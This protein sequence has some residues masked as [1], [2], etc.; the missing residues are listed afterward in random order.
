MVTEHVP[1]SAGGIQLWAEHPLLV[2]E[3]LPGILEQIQPESTNGLR[4]ILQWSSSSN[5]R[6]QW[7]A[8]SKL[9]ESKMPEDAPLSTAEKELL[10]QEKINSSIENF[11]APC[12]EFDNQSVQ[13]YV[14]R[15]I[16]EVA[17]HDFAVRGALGRQLFQTMSWAL[18][19]QDVADNPRYNPHDYRHAMVVAR[20]MADLARAEP[21]LLD[22]FTERYA[23][24]RTQ[25]LALIQLSGLLHDCGY[26]FMA[27]SVEPSGEPSKNPAHPVL[28]KATHAAVGGL[29]F[30]VLVQPALSRLLA[31]SG[32][33]SSQGLC[34]EMMRA[35]HLHS[36]DTPSRHD[37]DAMQVSTV[38]G[39]IY[40]V[41]DESALVDLSQKLSAMGDPISRVKLHE[42]DGAHLAH[43]S[44]LLPDDVIVT[45][46]ANPIPPARVL[47][48]Q[49]VGDRALATPCVKVDRQKIPMAYW[50][51]LADNLDLTHKRLGA[52][53]G[54]SVYGRSLLKFHSASDLQNSLQEIKAHIQENYA[55]RDEYADSAAWPNSPASVLLHVC[56]TSKKDIDFLVGL[57]SV[58]EVSLESRT[59]GQTVVVQLKPLPD[60]LKTQEATEAELT[61]QMRFQVDRLESALS[62]LVD[63][64]S[65]EVRWPERMFEENSGQRPESGRQ[66]AVA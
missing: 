40:Q 41:S 24:S 50:M 46:S 33:T 49:W 57:L 19:L 36:S 56:A 25:A 1:R 63:A 14:V 60:W 32:V 22:A 61:A 23:C 16:N 59:D 31:D 4:P 38:G 53:Q 18:F 35:I 37:T 8:L 28:T 30:H 26:P 27:D 12:A 48:A 6:D 2:R 34:R 11:A 20:W 51:M 17:G 3:N 10:I 29:M 58:A 52:I 47:D 15:L 21:Q 44:A 39:G 42:P 62:Y 65:V 9:I 66:Q 64:P 13:T 55:N 45:P 7:S 43:L 5:M 54:S